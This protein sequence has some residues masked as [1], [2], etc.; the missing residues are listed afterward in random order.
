VPGR[1]ELS[2]YR[3]HDAHFAAPL[4]LMHPLLKAEHFQQQEKSEPTSCPNNAYANRVERIRYTAARQ[5]YEGLR[6]SHKEQR[7][8][9]KGQ[10]LMNLVLVKRDGTS[11]QTI[12]SAHLVRPSQLAFVCFPFIVYGVETRS[13]NE[14]N[15]HIWRIFKS[16][17]RVTLEGGPTVMRVKCVCIR[18]GKRYGFEQYEPHPSLSWSHERVK[19]SCTRQA[20][21]HRENLSCRIKIGKFCRYN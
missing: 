20:Q 10:S 14:A 3:G 15:L 16:R 18:R 7:S 21:H 12:Q 11:H 6:L 4:R 8:R 19:H 1:G 17:E 13:E 9:Q 2:E 5:T